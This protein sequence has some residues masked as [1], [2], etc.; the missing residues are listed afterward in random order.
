MDRNLPANARDM[1]LIP[2]PGK[3]H[4]LWATKAP[5]PQLLSLHSRD[6]KPQLMSP[7]APTTEAGA[8]RAHAPQ[9][10][11]LLQWEAHA[12]QQ[13]A[14]PAHCIKKKPA[15]NREDLGQAKINKQ[16]FFQKEKYK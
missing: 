10:E 13:R 2:G 4:M 12:P 11:K 14:A 8:L 1:S 16:L 7:C 15:H 5:V 6:P 3:I 9:Q